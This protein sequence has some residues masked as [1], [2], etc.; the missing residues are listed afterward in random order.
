MAPKRK[1]YYI[2]NTLG[3]ALTIPAVFIWITG[4]MLFLGDEQVGIFVEIF[5]NLHEFIQF[6][7]WVGMPAIAVGFALTSYFKFGSSVYRMRIGSWSVIIFATILI[8][9][10]ILASL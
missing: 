1:L 2:F 9:F 8:L 7:V 4:V 3:F 10:A 5:D 6:F